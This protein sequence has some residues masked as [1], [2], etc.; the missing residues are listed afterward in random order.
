[1]TA[2]QINEALNSMQA[3]LNK[4]NAIT[5]TTT[6]LAQ[7]SLLIIACYA[8]MHDDVQIDINALR[9][10]TTIAS[11][12]SGITTGANMAAANMF[13]LGDLLNVVGKKLLGATCCY[14]SRD[15]YEQLDN[16][17]NQTSCCTVS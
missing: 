15:N 13:K 10:L 2:S 11:V 7:F 6:G 8:A 1:M 12:S 5:I 3:R 4:T 16:G 9:A 14:F 17:S